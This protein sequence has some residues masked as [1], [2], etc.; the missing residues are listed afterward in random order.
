MKVGEESERK[1]LSPL[2]KKELDH[3]ENWSLRMFGRQG[4]SNQGSEMPHDKTPNT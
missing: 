1:R 3:P 4:N 2:K